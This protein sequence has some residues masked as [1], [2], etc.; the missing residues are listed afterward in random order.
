MTLTKCVSRCGG[1]N[2][3]RPDDGQ[4]PG[5]LERGPGGGALQHHDPGRGQEEHSFHLYPLSIK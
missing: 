2:A 4:T 5:D 3:D 1:H